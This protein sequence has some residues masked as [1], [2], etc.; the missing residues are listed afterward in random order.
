MK[1]NWWQ[2]LE[3][4][5][6]FEIIYSARWL[7]NLKRE[8]VNL[9][10]SKRLK[11]TSNLSWIFGMLYSSSHWSACYF[12]NMPKHVT[13]LDF[14]S[15][16]ILHIWKILPPNSHRDHSISLLRCLFKRYLIR[17][18]FSTLLFIYFFFKFFFFTLL[19]KQHIPINL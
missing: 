9:M 10:G 19:F 14:L 15:F 12:L 2:E 16:A 6:I 11:D 17:N 13:A 3:R 5:R 4:I 7:L 1:S 18:K 8:K